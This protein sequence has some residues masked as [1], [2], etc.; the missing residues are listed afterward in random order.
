MVDYV[1]AT[2][3]Q[4]PEPDR[5]DVGRDVVIGVD[6]DGT[7]I[8]IRSAADIEASG[9]EVSIDVTLGDDVVLV[10]GL[11]D[12]HIHAPQWPQ[13]GTGLDLPLEDWLFEHTFPLEHLLTQAD[14]AAKVWPSMVS[15]LLRHGTTT[16]V[17]FATVDVETTTMLASTC[18]E[19][20]QRAFVGRVG[21]DHPDGTPRW[22]RDADASAGV[23]ASHLSI[24]Q[25]GALGSPLVRPIVTPRF[26]PA[27]T[28]ALLMGLGELAAST[29]TL[30]QTHCSESDWQHAYSI[31]RFGMSDANALDRFGF[32]ADHS[33]LA[34]GNHLTDRD[35]AMVRDQG[36]GVAHCPLSNAYFGNSVFPARRALDSGLRV[37]LGSDVAGGSRPGVL[38]QC[39]DAVTASRM[40]DDGV[41]PS[42]AA[43]A[44]GV[45]KSR[46]SITEAFWMGTVGGADLLGIPCGLFEVGR[47]FDAIAVRTRMPGSPLQV[48]DEIDDDARVFEKIVR[49][50][51]PAEISD[52]WVAGRRVT[53]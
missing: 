9:T 7:I 34:H 4:T 31:G 13:L 39:G 8:S 49:L 11:I 25:I 28:D 30:T 53:G 41:D 24:E 22:Y 40:L 45:P 14:C 32:V 43:H 48:W 5:L 20:G 37:G 12:T 51:G 33:V 15:T 3:M 23:A 19:L 26:V 29:G 42:I 6:D 1:R 18:A 44:R 36:A 17:Y 38:S 27:C 50:A 46:I 47:Q 16:A 10:P 21:M 35:M 2:F 52:V